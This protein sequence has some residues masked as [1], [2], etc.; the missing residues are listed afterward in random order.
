M[1][2]E[3]NRLMQRFVFIVGLSM[4]A[5]GLPA[6][7]EGLDYA[8]VTRV[9]AHE[10][11][12]GVWRFSVTVRHADT[13]WDHYADEW[14]V[15]DPA[16]GAVL[17]RRILAHP[18]VEEQPFTRSQSGIEIPGNVTTV[19]VRAKCNIHGFGGREITVDLTTD[20]GEDYE[21]TRR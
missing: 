7:E 13:G 20:G 1:Y 14:Q 4:V 3:Y 9:E 15:V 11:A 12:D 17:A 5:M 19:V 16:T 18:H 8:Q 6:H 21:V 2:I 10:T